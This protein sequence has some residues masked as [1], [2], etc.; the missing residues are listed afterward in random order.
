MT[1]TDLSFPA[2]IKVIGTQKA[3]FIFKNPQA[4]ESKVYIGAYDFSV[5]APMWKL[6]H[7]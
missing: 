5:E 3:A 1:A 7:N 4:S 6:T 2:A